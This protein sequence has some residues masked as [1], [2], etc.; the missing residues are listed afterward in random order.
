M[1]LLEKRH[2]LTN[3]GFTLIELLTV[4]ALIGILAA[5]LIPVTGA[6]RERGRRAVCLSNIRQQLF[7]MQLY[8]E[9]HNGR[10]FWDM[11]SAGNDGAPAQLYPDYTDDVKIFL[12]PSTKNTIDESLINRGIYWHLRDKAPNG[13]DDSSG[14]HSYEYFGFYGRYGPYQDV[15][16]DMQRMKAPNLIPEGHLSRTVLVVDADDGAPSLNNCPEP[17]NNHGEDGW[18]WSFA[19]GHVEWITRERTNEAFINSFHAPTCP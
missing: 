3:R 12:C 10:G 16:D 7:A 11:I 6:G 19:D 8:A 14:G 18:N 5:I 15:T 1:S 9:E 17:G 2:P 4:I 13:R